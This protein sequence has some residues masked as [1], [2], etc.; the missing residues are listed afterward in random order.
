MTDSLILSGKKKTWALWKTEQRFELW[1]H[2]VDR[3]KL[4]NELIAEF[5]KKPCRKE[6]VRKWLEEVNFRWRMR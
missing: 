5:D 4:R 1:A 3:E 2:V 6:V